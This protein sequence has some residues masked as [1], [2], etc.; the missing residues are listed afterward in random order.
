[1]QDVKVGYYTVKAS[2]GE[3]VEGFLLEGLSPEEVRVL[4]EYEDVAGG[5]YRRQTVEVVVEGRRVAAE[6]YLTGG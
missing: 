2:P 6:V 3:R 4:D 5:L 1:M